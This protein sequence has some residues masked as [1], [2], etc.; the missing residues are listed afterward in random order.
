M[1]SRKLEGN[2]FIPV[3]QFSVGGGCLPLGLWDVHP[4]GH[5][6]PATHLHRDGHWSGR[7][8][9]YWNVFLLNNNICNEARAILGYWI[10]GGSVLN[11][12]LHHCS[13]KE[14]GPHYLVQSHSITV[15]LY[16]EAIGSQFHYFIDAT[17]GLAEQNHCRFKQQI[18]VDAIDFWLVY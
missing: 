1:T 12:V 14:N 15:K 7:Y 16:N 10:S 4:P 13:G 8:T 5:P 11:T 3:C 18:P 6:P 9:S 2:V 17:V